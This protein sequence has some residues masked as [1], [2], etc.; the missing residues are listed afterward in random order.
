MEVQRNDFEVGIGNESIEISMSP[1]SAAS[2]EP[3]KTVR[4]AADVIHNINKRY[5]KV[6]NRHRIISFVTVCICI[7]VIVLGATWPNNDC[8]KEKEAK[9]YKDSRGRA[10]CQDQSIY[11]ILIASGG[12]VLFAAFFTFL[13]HEFYQHRLENLYGSTHK[14]LIDF[15]ETER[16]G[17]FNAQHE[18][19]CCS[20]DSEQLIS[21]RCLLLL[22]DCAVMNNTIIEYQ[23]SGRSLKFAEMSANTLQLGIKKTHRHWSYAGNSV[24]VYTYASFHSFSFVIPPSF[25]SMHKIRDY[26]GYLNAKYVARSDDCCC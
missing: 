15:V 26:V 8:A 4:T 22:D 21:E 13:N 2:L 6:K 25:A 17:A 16:T 7:V 18:D 20:C 3:P 23:R 5:S 14:I 24:H 9:T 1:Y 12:V 10:G 11:L 19:V